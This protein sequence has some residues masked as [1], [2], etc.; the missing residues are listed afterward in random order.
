MMQTGPMG[1]RAC[2]VRR[3]RPA[4]APAAGLVA[5]L[6][7][8]AG[9]SGSTTASPPPPAS[10]TPATAGPTSSATP[11][12]ATADWPAY[13][14]NAQ[15]TGAVAGL[16]AAGPLFI[17][18]SRR[19]DGAVYG[20][21]LIIG[22][23]VIAAT[24]SN[25]V[26][27]LSRATGRVLWSAQAA[28]GRA[29]PLSDQP[30]GDIN[31]LGITSTP[32]YD[33]ATRLVY[34]VAETTGGQKVMAGIRVSD[35]H[36]ALR[37]DIPA[38][39]GHPAYDQQRGALALADGRIYVVF[40]G[41]FGDCGPY[42]GSVAAVPASG[43]GPILTYVIPTVKQ[44][45]IW[46]SGGPVVS[47]WGTI[48]VSS[49]NGGAFHPPYDGSDSVIA[50]TPQLKRIGVFAPRRWPQ[51]N[52]GDLDLGSSSPALLPGGRI[53][54]VGKSQFGYLLNAR[55]LGGV[56]GQLAE[57]QVC[58]SFGGPAVSGS[59]VYVPC[60]GIGLSA[61]SVAGGRIQV[62]WRG[63]ATASGSPVVGGGAVWVADWN[64]GI[65]YQLDPA[66]GRVRH[67]IGLGSALPHFV[68]PS[69][70]GSLILVGTMHGVVAVSGA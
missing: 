4:L 59:V 56:G 65:L 48:Y 36:V 26:Y 69:L 39:D 20:Q 45:G 44:A 16:P 37:R 25:R 66:T 42:R 53:L 67:Q 31:P 41:H 30:C 58:A 43:T 29:V 24:E 11:G 6:A 5:L 18:W 17:H 7:A 23:T 49:G 40:G 19:L 28:S 33:P 46:A 1:P 10:S 21:P 2:P 52:S 47:P 60:Y 27:G 63:P 55:R 15:R 22:G 62:L 70:S 8:V 38:P 64:S 50:L 9:C 3:P 13:H 35:G 34:V 68:S 51:D 14:G 61:V 32:V 57:G 12:P 54:Q